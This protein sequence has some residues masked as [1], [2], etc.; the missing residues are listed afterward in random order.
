LRRAV[1]SPEV[2][3]GI[4]GATLGAAGGALSLGGEEDVQQAG[5]GAVIGGALG[6]ALGRRIGLGGARSVASAVEAPAASDSVLSQVRVATGIRQLPKQ[7]TLL[8]VKE[9]AMFDT[10]G[11]SNP[12][13]KIAG[14]VSPAEANRIDNMF[15][16]AAGSGNAAKQMLDDFITPLV[17][18][19]VDEGGEE[20]L[21]KVRQAAIV[22]RAYNS[23]LDIGLSP[24][25][26][27]RAIA[28]I[29][30][31]PTLMQATD[32]LHGFFRNLLRMRRDA[33]LIAEAD[34]KRIVDSDEYYTPFMADFYALGKNQ[35]ARSGGNWN[36]TDKGVRSMDRSPDFDKSFAKTDPFEVALSQATVTIRDVARADVMK[37]ID[38]LVN[39]PLGSQFMRRVGY[40]PNIPMG[41]TGNVVQA[42]V[43]GK[44][45]AYEIT[46]RD[47]FRAV[48]EQSELSRNMIMEISRR[49]AALKRTGIVAPP[50][51]ALLN[52]LRDVPAYAV[53]RTDVSR[54]LTEAGIGAVGGMAI[55]AA[56]A[57]EGD[58]LLARTLV[59]GTV[60]AGVGMLARPVAQILEAMGDIIGNRDIYKEWLRRGGSS[61]G[62]YI[63]AEP[64]EATKI[65]DAMK[66]SG[67]SMGDV[68]SPK[69]W[70]DAMLFI[71]SVA[72]QAPRLA[73]AK[74][75]IGKDFGSASTDLWAQAI[76]EGQDISVRF[77]RKGAGQAT[78]E[79]AAITPF[80]NAE[81][82]GWVKAF[83]LA[84]TPSALAQSAAIITGPT[85]ALWY[86]NK[87]NPEYWDRPQWERDIFWLV[88]KSDGGFWRVPK[89]FQ[90]GTV[91]ATIPERALSF[92]AQTGQI[93]SAAPQRPYDLS[94]GIRAGI[95]LGGEGAL[96]SVPIP[97]PAVA[98][99]GLSQFVNKDFFTGRE[100]VPQSYRGLPSEMQAMPRTSGFGRL[101][102]QIPGVSP[103]RVDKAVR[104][105]FGTA[106]TRVSEAI[107]DP[108]LRAA[109]LDA[110]VQ[111]ARDTGIGSGLLRA[112]GAQ[113]FV[114]REY[115]ATETEY[116]ARDRMYNLSKVDR[117]L[118]QLRN[119][120]RPREEIAAYMDANRE[121]L[122]AYNALSRRR[123]ALDRITAERRDIMRRRD[124]TP[125][126]RDEMLDRLKARGDRIARQIIEYDAR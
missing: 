114:T 75:V 124:I 28:E 122:R 18:R 6:G 33:G 9:R 77:A 76:K 44:K 91:F 26:M 118:T 68:V 21:Q 88:P 49:A 121:D 102:G 99:L 24:D 47:L 35:N 123:T 29:E 52:F 14:D 93:S 31:N 4:I 109:G 89:P 55:G 101:A 46:D 11:T 80:W 81:L 115:D 51:F 19:V 37:A 48:A 2:A 20:L 72:E 15:A 97:I 98:D 82:Q 84:R 22:R 5:V 42:I 58:N 70:L 110:P 107:V 56:T 66:K 67:I 71:G 62:F 50:D 41:S 17:R 65:L 74:T 83:Q 117:G 45:V 126:R 59:G 43:D 94:G 30:A 38:G 40:N 34:Y 119:E 60:G 125:E 103:L 85:M 39:A 23:N 100:I 113:R 53:Q 27:K 78:R 54:G 92:A 8:S 108:A 7:E 63:R 3:S 96:G 111:R 1:G 120:R 87:D 25:D 32:E 57:E 10:F 105:V 69:K 13:L 79:I 106:G 12:I 36:V 64:K 61:E 16:V 104:D 95:R 73:R 112:T 86:V 90:I 116:A